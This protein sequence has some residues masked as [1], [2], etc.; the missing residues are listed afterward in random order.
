MKRD[1]ELEQQFA[2]YYASLNT[3]QQEEL[4]FFIADRCRLKSNENDL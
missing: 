4:A 2:D 1:E 3:E